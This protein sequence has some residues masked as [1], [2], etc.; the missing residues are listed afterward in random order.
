MMIPARACTIRLNRWS[1]KVRI[2]L[3]S[4]KRI[5]YIASLSIMSS[6]SSPASTAISGMHSPDA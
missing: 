2:G 1:T 5:P 3:M 6:R 4:R